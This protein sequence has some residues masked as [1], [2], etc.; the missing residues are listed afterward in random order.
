MSSTA[1]AYSL[2]LPFALGLSCFALV[3][4]LTIVLPETRPWKQQES[5]LTAHDSS[6][7]GENGAGHAVSD[8]TTPLL[9]DEDP[10]ATNTDPQQMENVSPADDADPATRQ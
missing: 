3:L 7:P 5:T 2:W 10:V 4:V 6:E 8:V 9:A 1:L